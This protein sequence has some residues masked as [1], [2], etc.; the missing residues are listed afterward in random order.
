MGDLN[1]PGDSP[2]KRKVKGKVEQAERKAP[3]EVG[4][5]GGDTATGTGGLAEQGRGKI[6]EGTPDTRPEWEKKTEEHREPPKP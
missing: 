4:K 1:R 3:E 2:G 6:G 5:L